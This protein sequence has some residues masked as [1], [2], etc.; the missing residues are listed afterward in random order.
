MSKQ[1]SGSAIKQEQHLMPKY[2]MRQIQIWVPD[3]QHPD[4]A[5]ECQRK[6]RM[7]KASDDADV[8][9]ND[10]MDHVLKDMMNQDSDR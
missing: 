3:T 4:F 2:G 9:L 7:A 8:N 6:L 1:D 5:Q 10:F